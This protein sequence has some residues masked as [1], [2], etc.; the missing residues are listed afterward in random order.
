MHDIDKKIERYVEYLFRESA[1]KFGSELDPDYLN[2]IIVEDWEYA[3]WL[4]ELRPFSEW[5]DSQQTTEAD[6]KRSELKTELLEELYTDDE[7]LKSFPNI[8]NFV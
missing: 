7:E 4:F 2:S 6:F 1:K 5:V 3:A 8:N